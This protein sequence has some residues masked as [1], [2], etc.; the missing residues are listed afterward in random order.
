MKLPI[1]NEENRLLSQFLEVKKF[2]KAIPFIIV[3]SIPI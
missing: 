3:E 1:A 2:D